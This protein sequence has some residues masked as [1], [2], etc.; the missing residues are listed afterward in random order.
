MPARGRRRACFRK[1]TDGERIAF[2][3]YSSFHYLTIRNS[4]MA[5]DILKTSPGSAAGRVC[6]GRATQAPVHDA[7]RTCRPYRNSLDWDTTVG[8]MKEGRGSEFE[9]RMFDRFL[10]LLA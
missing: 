7:L 1:R 9:P 8:I 3:D 2:R 6:T 4:R 10:D 5:S